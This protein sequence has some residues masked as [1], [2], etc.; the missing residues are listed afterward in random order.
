MLELTSFWT[1]LF[2]D[3]EGALDDCDAFT[4]V[5]QML[6]LHMIA[7]KGRERL[8]NC[9][10]STFPWKT[11][12]QPASGNQQQSLTTQSPWSLSA[13][14]NRGRNPFL[15]HINK[16]PESLG[17]PHPERVIS[18][19]SHIKVHWGLT[20]KEIRRVKFPSLRQFKTLLQ[21][22]LWWNSPVLLWELPFRKYFLSILQFFVL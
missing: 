15:E 7:E 2:L 20:E 9:T 19:T 6:K 1:G 18:L 12:C 11:C 8:S 5:M 14:Q 4:A 3:A 17:F 16:I 21:L 10:F 22:K 13:N